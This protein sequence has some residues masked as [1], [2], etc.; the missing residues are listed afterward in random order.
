MT[1][2]KN[3]KK[4]M[5]KKALSISLVAAMLA[6]SNVPVWAAEDLFSDG[7]SA[8]VEAPVVEEP[9]AEVEAFSAEPAE[10]APVVEE[11]DANDIT[12]YAATGVQTDL[13]LV[14]S[15]TWGET[16]KL[17]EGTYLKDSEGKDINSFEYE[18]LIDGKQPVGDNG[19]SWNN[20][21]TGTSVTDLLNRTYTFA[22][23]HVDS[24]VSVVIR[25][26]GAF[27][28]IEYV[29]SGTKVSA[30]DI[31]DYTMELKVNKSVDYDGKAKNFT[32]K[33]IDI[34][35]ELITSGEITK[36][37]F[38]LSYEGDIVNASEGKAADK[39]P[40]LVAK[41]NK[42]GYKGE[43]KTSFTIWKR[44]VTASDFEVKS[45][46]KEFAYTGKEIVP[47]SEAIT[48]TSKID[49]V[50]NPDLYTVSKSSQASFKDAGDTVSLRAI[51]KEELLS[52]DSTF[53]SNY[54][55]TTNPVYVDAD[56]SD[57]VK[58][59]SRQLSDTTITSDAVLWMPGHS[60]T[61][62]DI[63]K[64]LHF[65]DAEGNSLDL[66]NDVSVSVPEITGTGT[67]QIKVTG[68][69]NASGKRNVE[70]EK[71]LSI[72]VVTNT[73][74]GA[75]FANEAYAT[76]DEWYTGKEIKKDTKILGQLKK[77]NVVLTEG[78]DYE[79]VYSKNIDA[80][81][82]TLV[83]KGIG[84]FGGSVTYKFKINPATI[85]S[86]T[87]T[88]P[89][90][91]LYDGAKISVEDYLAKKDI[92]VKANTKVRDASGK[93]VDTTID[94]PA[95]S[96]DVEFELVKASGNAKTSP[97]LNDTI[98]TTVVNKDANFDGTASGVKISA[99]KTTTISNRSLAE[100]AAVVEV[101]GGPYTYTG[102]EITP[103][104]KVTYDGVEL[105]KDKD[106]EIL[107]VSNATEAGDATVTVQGIGDYSGTKTA[108]FTIN[109]ADISDVVIAPKE[110]STAFEYTGKQIKP[111]VTEFDI[112]LNG[113]DVSSNFTIAY[114][115]SSYDNVE[116]GTGNGTLTPTTGNENFTGGTKAFTFEIQPKQ[117]A[118]AGTITAWD[119]DGKV[120]TLY[121]SEKDA[122]DSIE[123]G[124]ATFHYD[125]TEKKFAEIKFTPAD[126]NLKEGVDYEVKY[127]NN[128]TGPTA[129]IYVNAIG[130]Y[131][132]PK[133]NKFDGSEQTYANAAFFSI[134]GVKV[135][136][137]NIHV[138]D[139]AYGGGITLKPNVTI[140]VGGRNLVEG[141]DFKFT[142]IKGDRVNVTP[143]NTVLKATIEFIGGYSNS[144]KITIDWKIVAKDLKDTDITATKADGVLNVTVMNGSVQVPATEYD[145]KDNGDG[146]VTVSAKSTSTCYTGS[147]TVTLE[148]QD[149]AIGTPIISEVKVNG[150]KI[151]VVL[152]GE[153]DGATGYDYVIST[154]NDYQNGRLPNGINKNQLTTSTTYQYIDQGMY[155]AYCHAWKRVNG[156]KVFSDWSNI[157]P[158]S[159]S[160]I[161]PEKPTITSVKKS[162]RNVTVTWTQCDNA[163]GY[164]VVL[165]TALRKVNGELRPVEY[166][167]AVKKL[168]KNTYSVT[169]K[170]CPKGAT[171]YAGLH[172]WN[173]TSETGVKVFS[174]W[175]DSVKVTI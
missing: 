134:E 99:E 174:E 146:T 138:K 73:I 150:N 68:I 103:E 71:T 62:D 118:I 168:G 151:E 144:N 14:S 163:Q 116:V 54:K 25:G 30:K 143:A 117:M 42:A 20:T 49:G 145:V 67:Y 130:N 158:F 121:A 141:V 72:S 66:G 120:V 102:K 63:K 46:V 35:G 91:V 57:T 18:I 22:A 87:I 124:K 48:V 24:D 100:D 109:P 105:R 96:Y 142:D 126:K 13:K 70:G 114:P 169:F 98:K 64:G 148:D 81:T 40:V 88:V 85:A 89:E 41:I 19:V 110:D 137:E 2:L 83:V 107:T 97:E 133:V 37:D 6:T 78:K 160:A 111:D 56:T 9:A 29:L 128:I 92:T 34:H 173:R 36:E 94:V 167:K 69:V 84:T 51:L 152:A 122:S 115:I 79:I 8:A 171:F 131:T 74:E 86:K 61:E 44:V 135:Y 95:A 32:T 136:K 12:T 139:T 129:A 108:K 16:T 164:D 93:L 5:A 82:A 156:V 47:D 90:T 45:N 127:Y 157:M 161:T 140:T 113:V 4:G 11:A 165:G 23:S 21:F 172:A 26:T 119:E 80:G 43:L 147:Q 53:N 112:T 7:S 60:Y 59:V 154:A 65:T 155:Y 33:D 28:G 52:K 101:V 27:E 166:G 3:T 149:T 132:N 77:D 153:C 17:I 39:Q 123:S 159:V 175:S 162:G 1:K 104:L 38:V 15:I 50:I 75:K 58:V 76:E 170:S 55:F 106:Y 10:E 125:G 31:S